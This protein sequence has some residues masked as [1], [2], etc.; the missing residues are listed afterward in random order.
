MSQLKVDGASIRA[1]IYKKLHL[2]MMWGS[3]DPMCHLR[4]NNP[5]L[6]SIIESFKE[7]IPSMPSC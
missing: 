1:G 7:G 2:K 3:L 4:V 5:L 6:K